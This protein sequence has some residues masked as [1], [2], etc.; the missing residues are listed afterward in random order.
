MGDSGVAPNLETADRPSAEA[1]DGQLAALLARQRAFYRSGATLSLAFR[2]EQLRAFLDAVIRFEKKILDAQYTD[3]RRPNAE[4]YLSEVGGVTTEIRHTLRHLPG[5]MKPKRRL[6][7]LESAPS[8]STL[9]HQPLGATLILGAWNYSFQLTLVPLLG[10]ICAGNISVVKP[11]EL[12]PASSEVIA[13]MVKET[14]SEEHVAAVEGGID[15]SQA[16][17]RQKW[18]HLFFTGGT[19]VGRIVA[20]AGAEHL[21]RVTLELGGKSPT[22][23]TDSAEVDV[24]ARRIVFGK[25]FNSGQTCIAPDYVLAHH[26]VREHLVARMTQAIEAF[27]GKDPQQSGDYGRIVNDRHFRRLEALLD[28]EK[29]ATGGQSDA[30]DRYISPTIMSDVTLE[31]PIM[32][33]EIFGPILPVLSY[34]TLEDAMEII[35]QRPNP[36]ALYLFTSSESD[37]NTI[38]DR[39]SF[40]GGCINNA[41]YHFTDKRLPFGGVGTSGLGAYHGHHSFEA[42]SHCKGVLK[43]ATWIDPDIKYPPFAKKIGLLRKIVR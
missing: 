18:D 6:G 34:D 10:S 7:P 23:V 40:G 26:S 37:E 12:A 42:F 35:E 9:H 22:I 32:A 30:A 39:V 14:F 17:L 24:A 31:D 33:D 2:E 13:E 25:F 11:S 16:L 4:A 38:I 1:L 36:L 43:S 29:I 8:S 5:W 20:K 21:S 19:S 3:L 15:V 28:P 27:Y 41:I